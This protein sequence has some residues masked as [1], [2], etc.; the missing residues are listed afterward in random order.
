MAQGFECA[1]DGRDGD[2][3]VEF[4]G[5]FFAEA[6]RQIVGSKIVGDAEAH[7]P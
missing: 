4:G 3:A 6:P 7:G 2:L 5:F 1:A